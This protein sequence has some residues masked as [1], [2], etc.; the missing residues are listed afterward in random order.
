[1]ALDIA[2]KC[3]V[4][5]LEDG[6][7][8]IM[9]LIGPASLQ[10]RYLLAIIS[11]LNIT[12][13]VAE[14]LPRMRNMNTTKS[15]LR[16]QGQLE[17]FLLL[18]CVIIEYTRVSTARKNL[19][20]KAKDKLVVQKM[21]SDRAGFDVTTDE[22]DAVAILLSS[23]KAKLSEYPIERVDP[24]TIKIVTM[25]KLQRIVSRALANIEIG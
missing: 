21:I 12:K 1:M 8:K 14:D 6:I 9:V 17:C 4:A 20:T 7:I 3:G 25:G 23:L 22:A 16:R 5:Y 11:R 24:K 18:K 10:A 13:V 19:G 15:L 2:K